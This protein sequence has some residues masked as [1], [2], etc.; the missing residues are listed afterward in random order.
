[1]ETDLHVTGLFPLAT[2]VSLMEDAGSKTETLPLPGDGDG[3]GEHM[4]SGILQKS[5]A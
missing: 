2:W 5:P 4:F 3:C 1:V